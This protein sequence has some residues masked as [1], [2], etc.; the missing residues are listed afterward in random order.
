MFA[1][2]S[3]LPFFCCKTQISNVQVEPS[4]SSFSLGASEDFDISLRH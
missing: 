4:P 3:D 2:P 1:A